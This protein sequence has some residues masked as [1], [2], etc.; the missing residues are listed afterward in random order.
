MRKKKDFTA[1][2]TS[3]FPLSQR[4]TLR[5][6]LEINASRVHDGLPPLK[7]IGELG[8]LYE[9]RKMT[10]ELCGPCKDLGYT[11]I[12][13]YQGKSA[14][15]SRDGKSTPPK[16]YYHHFDMPLPR[17][18]TGKDS[19][20]KER[21]VIANPEPPKQYQ[22]AMRQ[23]MKIREG[24]PT[25]RCAC[26]PDCDKMLRADSSHNYYMGHRQKAKIVVAGP[27]ASQVVQS[28]PSIE[29]IPT[30]PVNGSDKTITVHVTE[31]ALNH[32]W[33][34]LTLPE[35]AKVIFG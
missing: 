19:P 15:A 14:S 1:R 4:L 31:K 3:R 20:T 29:V 16:C 12:A 7:W 11:V 10:Q 33:D 6:R 27:I 25:K 18:I 32:I 26:S 21:D 17:S 34:R 22:P 28:E 30:A 5:V 9:G 2:G 23:T 8:F 24:E 13:H 35:K